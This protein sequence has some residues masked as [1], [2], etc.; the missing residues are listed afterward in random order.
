MLKSMNCLGK[1]DMDKI[2]LKGTVTPDHQLVL[3]LP[4]DLPPGPVEVEIRQPSVEGVS[5]GQLLESG[6][7]GLWI[8]RTEIGDGVD[9]ARQLRHRA[10]RR[11]AE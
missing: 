8:D 11:H 3:D 4:P 10:S 1:T 2:I 9:F 6:L 5:L 7:V